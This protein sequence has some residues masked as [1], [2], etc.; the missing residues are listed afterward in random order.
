MEKRKIYVASSWRNGYFDRVVTMLIQKG[1]NVYNFR[2]PPAGGKGF[3]W[4]DIDR[5]WEE[6]GTRQYVRALDNAIAHRGF[7]DD[8]GGLI[9]ADLCLLVLP[10]GRSAHTEAGYMKG[11]G[12][13]VYV[14][15]PSE[16]EPELMYKLYDGIIPDFGELETIFTIGK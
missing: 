3:S 8:L 6:W 14:Y 5:D 9:W 16:Q 2:N 4:A 13:L 1:H 10:S 7:N 11:L 15:Q 12:K